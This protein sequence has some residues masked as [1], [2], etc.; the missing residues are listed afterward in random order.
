MLEEE[1][2]V[3]KG[4][5]DGNGEWNHVGMVDEIFD[6]LVSF[7]IEEVILEDM[8]VVGALWVALT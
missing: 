6:S 7:V 2:I 3:L 1:K 8:E 5:G 4:V